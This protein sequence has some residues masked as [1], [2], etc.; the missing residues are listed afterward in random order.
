VKRPPDHFALSAYWFAIELHWA[1]LLGAA[2]QAQIA[3]F[4]APGAIGT[5]AAIIGGVGAALSIVSQLAAGR[6]SDMTRRRL[7]FMAVG[8]LADVVA[9]FAFALAPSFAA[10]IAAFAGVE[11]AFNISAGPYQA[12][13]PDRVPKNQQG[14]ASGVMGLYRFLGTACGLL[15]A[16]LFVRQPGPR[17]T[18]HAFT[19]GLIELAGAISVVLIVALA[20]TLARVREADTGAAAPQPLLA[21]WPQRPSFAW[22]LVARAFASGALYLILPFLAFYLRFALHVRSYIGTSLDLLMLMVACALIGTISAGAVGDRASKK[23]IILWSFAFLAGGALVLAALTGVVW[24][25]FVGAVL[26]LAWGAYYSVDWALACNLLPEGRAG[27]LMAVWNIGASGP[28]VGSVVLGGLLV[29]RVG[30]AAGEP[31]AGY[32]ALFV[33][34]AALLILAAASIAFVREPREGMALRTN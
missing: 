19:L 11:I 34:I 27:M 18:P 13:I 9:L 17:V 26:G 8:T 22:L 23:K 33:L 29:D 5:A 25:W 16:R 4:I 28:Q 10:V 15:L 6:A 21:T 12:L 30:A 32:R 3:R 14:K 31:G 24:T 20:I 1:V 2:L 7:P